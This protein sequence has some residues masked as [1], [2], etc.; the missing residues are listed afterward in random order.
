METT[1]KKYRCTGCYGEC[2]YKFKTKTDATI[3]PNMCGDSREN[4]KL[5]SEST[6]GKDER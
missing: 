3:L 5:I 1:T 4:F 6:E 2:E